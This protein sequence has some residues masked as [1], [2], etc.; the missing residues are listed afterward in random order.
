MRNAKK[1][2]VYCSVD[3]LND[4]VKSLLNKIEENKRVYD[5]EGS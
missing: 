4:Y 2:K 1:E 5:I 3:E